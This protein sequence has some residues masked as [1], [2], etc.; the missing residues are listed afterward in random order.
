MHRPKRRGVK[1]RQNKTAGQWAA[2]A[3]G[4]ANREGTRNAA[5]AF[6][7]RPQKLATTTS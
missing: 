1:Q 7:S 5:G 3:E 4:A 2:A 6:F